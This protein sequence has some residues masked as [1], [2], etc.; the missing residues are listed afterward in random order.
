M[1]VYHF[2]VSYAFLLSLVVSQ[3]ILVKGLP[4]KN[5]S[6]GIASDSGSFAAPGDSVGC[7]AQLLQKMSYFSS[8]ILAWTPLSLSLT[9]EP[10]QKFDHGNKKYRG[11]ICLL[12]TSRCV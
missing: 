2:L 5:D 3:A 6:R 10:H 8:I 1:Y 11:Y 7:G 9:S 12:Y 4:Q